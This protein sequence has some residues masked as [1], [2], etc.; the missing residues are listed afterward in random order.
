M[1]VCWCVLAFACMSVYVCVCALSSCL[2]ISVFVYPHKYCTTAS[3]FRNYPQHERDIFM[4]I[5]R[6]S[7]NYF[8]ANNGICSMYGFCD[9][10]IRL[11]V[12]AMFTKNSEKLARANWTLQ[13]ISF[14]FDETLA[15]THICDCE[16]EICSRFLAEFRALILNWYPN[17]SLKKKN[18]HCYPAMHTQWPFQFSVVPIFLSERRHS[19]RTLSSILLT[20]SIQTHTSTHARTMCGRYT[21]ARCCLMHNMYID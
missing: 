21:R 9:L 17:Y 5:R 1:L 20:A 13:R 11:D 14:S 8:T 12:S 18:S 7:V 19:P 16:N 6:I 3:L 15:R 4:L 2:C 10:D